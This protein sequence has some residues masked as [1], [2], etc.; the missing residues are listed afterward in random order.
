MSPRRRVTAARP[1]S[2][3]VRVCG[4]GDDAG[5]VDSGEER[6]GLRR[7]VAIFKV[8]LGS[9]LGGWRM[10]R[11]CRREVETSGERSS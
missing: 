3:F 6:G 4:L 9:L 7:K 1:D 8:S 11:R 10:V 2:C 5:V